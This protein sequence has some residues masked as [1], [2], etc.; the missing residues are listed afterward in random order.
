MSDVKTIIPTEE[1]NEQQNTE[2]E[3]LEKLFAETEQQDMV[4]TIKSLANSKGKLIRFPNG[5]VAFVGGS[6]E[7]DLQRGIEYVEQYAASHIDHEYDIVVAQEHI[8]AGLIPDKEITVK[9]RRLLY[10]KATQNLCDFGNNEIANLDDIPGKECLSVEAAIELLTR[11]AEEIIE[12]DEEDEE[13][14]DEEWEDEE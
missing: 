1:I 8:E 7:E 11:K 3:R 5:L 10:Y 12:D 13:R 4:Q 2:N 14:E 9:G 6:D